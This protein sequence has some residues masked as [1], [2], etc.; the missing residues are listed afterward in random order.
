MSPSTL[1]KNR[2]KK[3]VAATPTGIA[4]AL[5]K[6]LAKLTAMLDIQNIRT[7]PPAMNLGFIDVNAAV[8][9]TQA[10]A[11]SRPISSCFQPSPGEV[12]FGQLS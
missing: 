7:P 2:I 5:A 9:M 8:G 11:Q 6:G 3:A 1:L 10:V 12:G 4:K